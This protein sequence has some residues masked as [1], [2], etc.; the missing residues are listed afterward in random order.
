MG[1]ESGVISVI[2][3]IAVFCIHNYDILSVPHDIVRYYESRHHTNKFT[4]LAGT[5]WNSSTGKSVQQST[6]L[7]EDYSEMIP[8]ILIYL[9]TRNLHSVS[10]GKRLLSAYHHQ[11]TKQLEGESV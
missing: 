11:L 4:E 2:A 9:F 10:M 7:H 1:T 6:Q 5:E 3:M 8:V